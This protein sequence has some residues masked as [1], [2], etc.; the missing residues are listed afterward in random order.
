[1][2]R[3]LRLDWDETAEWDL[4]RLRAE[5]DA[6]PYPRDVA[7][8]VPTRDETIGGV[9]ARWF[10][11]AGAPADGV[12]L[13]FHGGSYLYGSARHS[14]AELVASLAL[15]SRRRVVAPDYRLAPEHPFPA[16]IEDARAVFDALVARGTPASRVVLAGDSAGGHLAI[17]LA[18]ALRDAGAAAPAG[19]V[20]I[21]PWSDLRMLGAS[22]RDNDAYD[23]GTREALV[24]HRDAFAGDV[25][26]DDPRISPVC[27]HLAGLPPTLVTVGDREI[28]RDDILALADA[29]EKAGVDTTL[30]VAEDMPH[31][32]P[33][34]AA[35]H[36]SGKA[37]LEASARFAAARLPD[38]A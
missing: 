20:L 14:H 38:R 18:L 24:R 23:F 21:S 12:I 4:L 37:A 9:P 1:M 6:R 7:R 2:V 27:A 26:L 35:V 30:H 16:Q 25:P 5:V 19:L 32:A 33:V 15:S 31:N 13:F 8:K 29:L 17:E 36:P 3:Y 10:E 11:P 22:F 28:P 34:W